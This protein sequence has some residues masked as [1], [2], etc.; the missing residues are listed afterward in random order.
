[1]AGRQVLRI[2][3][4]SAVEIIQRSE[5]RRV[6]ADGS[7]LWWDLRAIEGRM[8]K[9]ATAG[10]R[11]DDEPRA[12]TL[13]ESIGELHGPGAVLRMKFDLC[14]CMSAVNGDLLHLRI[15][16]LKI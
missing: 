4:S 7:L 10:V 6:C 5:N 15:E 16:R 8:G 13:F 14:P 11:L 2:C 12:V 9:I 1:M 3:Y